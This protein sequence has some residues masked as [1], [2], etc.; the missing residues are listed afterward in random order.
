MSWMHHRMP[1]ILR[2]QN[3]INEWL[4]YEKHSSM[5]VL[6]NFTKIDDVPKQ[7]LNHYAVNKQY[8]NNSSFND[9]KC[10]QRLSVK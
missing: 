10:M 7:V 5:D 8:V 9:I 3:E 4:H 2:T 6:S 1:I